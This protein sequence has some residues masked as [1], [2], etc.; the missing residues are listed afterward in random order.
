MLHC[1]VARACSRHCWVITPINSDSLPITGIGVWDCAIIDMAS[2]IFVVEFRDGGDF[3]IHSSDEKVGKLDRQLF[4]ESLPIYKTI[5]AKK[6]LGI[7]FM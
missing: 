1:P 5:E 3:L 2:F 4:G 6:N 7:F